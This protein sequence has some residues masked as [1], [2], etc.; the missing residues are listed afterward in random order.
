MKI[1]VTTSFDITPTG[2]T[3]HFRPARLPF[4]DL[5]GQSVNNENDWNRSRN[6]QRNWETLTQLIS[7]RTQADHSY[8]VAHK[9]RWTFDF[10][11][12]IET[13]LSDGNDPV[14]LLKQDC[15][16]VPMLTGL[17]EKKNVANTL[18]IM[19]KNQNIWFEVI[20]VN[21]HYDGNN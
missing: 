1:R 3:G 13:A 2:V 12:D 19:G 10:D 17:K 20:P 6:Q 18:E 7:L 21:I 11:I 14:A 5:S 15:A 16:G 8:P 4:N 9:Q